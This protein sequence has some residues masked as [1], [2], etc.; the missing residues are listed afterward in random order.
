MQM[1]QILNYLLTH[2]LQQ[3]SNTRLFHPITDRG[4]GQ[5]GHASHPPKMPKVA[6]WFACAVHYSVSVEINI[7][8]I[9]FIM[10][11]V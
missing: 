10:I 11:L 7:I 8:A 4:G 1:S 3:A 5:G 6:L 2:F 9:I